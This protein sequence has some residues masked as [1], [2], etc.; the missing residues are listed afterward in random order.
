MP[1]DRRPIEPVQMPF[2]GP[3]PDKRA[4]DVEPVPMPFFGPGPERRDVNPGY[5]SEAVPMPFFGRGP[6]KR[7][8][9]V[10]P[11]QLP[12]FGPP[13]GRFS[14]RKPRGGN[15]WLELFIRSLYGG[16]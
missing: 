1:A 11:V 2:F 13:A 15:P 14:A 6:M 12:F 8:V 5:G 7:P 9:D 3:G 10:E 16:Y 4:I